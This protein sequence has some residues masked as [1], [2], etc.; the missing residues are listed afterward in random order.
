MVAT[1]D[2]SPLKSRR[3]DIPITG[4]FNRRWENVNNR[5]IDENAIPPA[6][7]TGGAGGMAAKAIGG[8][9]RDYSVG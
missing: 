3:D 8:D 4:G 9:Y 1:A 2:D 6:P 7:P 5:I